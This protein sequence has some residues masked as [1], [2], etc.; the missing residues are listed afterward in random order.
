[1][2]ISSADAQK[3]CD[4][5]VAKAEELG[6]N[7]T[8]SVV[9]DGLELRAV[10]RMDGARGFNFDLSSRMA[11]TAGLFRL[12]GDEM[13]GRQGRGWFHALSAARAGK[14]CIAS[15]CLPIRRGNEFIGAVGV[16]GAPDAVDLEIAQAGVA[17][18]G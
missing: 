14:I 5:G 1:M 7:I 8:I 17:A 6:R 10:R 13:E 2:G 4:A 18:L 9:D 12:S 3:V 11:Y 15:G 16:S